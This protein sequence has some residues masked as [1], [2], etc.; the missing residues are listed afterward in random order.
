MPGLRTWVETCLRSV[1][2]ME[3]RNIAIR[4]ARLLWWRARG[5]ETHSASLEDTTTTRASSEAIAP[6]AVRL[7]AACKDSAGVQRMPRGLRCLGLG[8]RQH[9]SRWWSWRES[10]K[11]EPDRETE[12]KGKPSQ[13][14]L[15]AES[16]E[17]VIPSA[18]TSCT[19]FCRLCR[20]APITDSRSLRSLPYLLLH[21]KLAMRP[22][23][24]CCRYVS[25]P[26]VTSVMS[27]A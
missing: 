12:L 26:E 27:I 13:R 1:P 19:V 10:L 16:G 3:T 20:S 22:V 18:S 25:H 21:C 5:Q 8:R 15:K 2:E 9:R 7:R 23:F 11:D 24:C 4:L 14:S 6:A 17:V